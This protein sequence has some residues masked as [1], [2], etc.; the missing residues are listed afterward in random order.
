MPVNVFEGNKS[1]FLSYNVKPVRLLEVIAHL[2]HL[3][4][5]AIAKAHL[6][7]LTNVKLY[8]VIKMQ[9][10]GYDKWDGTSEPGSNEIQSQLSISQEREHGY[11]EADKL[12]R[13]SAGQ[14][15]DS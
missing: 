12:N 6:P 14:D 10:N 3:N 9:H 13:Q 1:G 2:L 15:C 11:R 8:E 4:Q 7:P 5:L